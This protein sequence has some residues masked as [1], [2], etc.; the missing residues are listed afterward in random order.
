VESKTQET[1]LFADMRR[2]LANKWRVDVIED[3]SDPLL[4]NRVRTIRLWGHAPARRAGRLEI[5]AL[6]SQRAG[7]T[8]LDGLPE[9]EK[10]SLR[11]WQVDYPGVSLQQACEMQLQLNRDP[12]LKDLF[13]IERADFRCRWD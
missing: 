8:T 2:L 7:L 5:R 10:Q 12:V 13:A 11:T 3:R 4:P 1:F 9:K 6:V